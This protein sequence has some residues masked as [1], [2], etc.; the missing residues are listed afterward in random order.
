[1]ALAGGPEEAGLAVNRLEAGVR[2]S[3]AVFAPVLLAKRI[4]RAPVPRKA[5]QR[6]A[7]GPPEACSGEMRA[8]GRTVPGHRRGLLTKHACACGLRNTTCGDPVALAPT[9]ACN[10]C[11]RMSTMLP[12]VVIAE[13]CRMFP[14]PAAPVPCVWEE[15]VRRG[16]VGGTDES[17]RLAQAVEAR[18]AG[19]VSAGEPSNYVSMNRS[20]LAELYAS[21]DPETFTD[22]CNMCCREGEMMK[23]TRMCDMRSNIPRSHM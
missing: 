3:I 17:H 11:R 23:L 16:L 2:S 14:D 22:L 6:D 20:I 19:T 10:V 5:P 18:E 7:T 15:S 8:S 1:M 9:G 4:I 13:A 12:R 21:V